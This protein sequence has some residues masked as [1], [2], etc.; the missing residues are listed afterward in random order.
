MAVTRHLGYYRTESG[1]VETCLRPTIYHLGPPDLPWRGFISDRGPAS[2]EGQTVLANDRN[3]GRL[4]LIASRH[5]D[6]D[7]ALP[8]A[9]S[10]NANQDSTFLDVSDV[11]FRL[12]HFS[13]RHLWNGHHVCLSSV[14]MSRVRSRIL[15]D[16]SAKFRHLYGKSG[17]E[18]K[19]LTSDFAPEVAKYPQK[20]Q[21]PQ[22]GISITS[23]Q[24]YCLARLSDA[25]C[26]ICSGN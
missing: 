21:T 9:A 18:S 2:S 24:A 13:V 14:C 20:T 10:M 15:R 23:V 26:L 7:D 4:R 11:I 8:V 16:M 17:S 3:G 25:A 6:D 19:N 12:A 1:G 22:M 5:D